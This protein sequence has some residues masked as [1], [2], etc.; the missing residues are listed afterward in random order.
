MPRYGWVPNPKATRAYRKTLPWASF[1]EAIGGAGNWAGSSEDGDA[2]LYRCVAKCMGVDRVHSRDQGQIGSCV[3]HGTATAG[4]ITAAV[5]IVLKNEPEEWVAQMSSAALYGMGRQIANQL[6]GWEGSNG[7]WAAEAV[8]KMGTLYML[9]YPGHD[10]RTYSAQLAGQFQRKGLDSGLKEIAAQ[11][12]MGAAAPVRSADEAWTALINGYGVNVCSN[13]G[14]SG[15]RDERGVM[16][17]QGSWNHSMAWIACLTIDG[18]RYFKVQQSWGDNWGS[19]PQVPED[20]PYGSFN[21]SWED[22]DRMVKQ[23]DSYCYSALDGFK[24]RSLWDF[25]RI[26]EATTPSLWT[27]LRN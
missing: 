8:T 23:D 25:L 21:I 7:S 20:S 10:L 4:D 14:F 9:E 15:Q 16:R 13:V 27:F 6:G 11:H 5:E 3:G 18:K 22:A 17:R 26:K 12:K 1:T 2:L 19:G 24:R